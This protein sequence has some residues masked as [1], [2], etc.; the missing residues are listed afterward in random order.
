MVCLASAVSPLRSS[1]TAVCAVGCATTGQ[2]HRRLAMGH[3]PGVYRQTLLSPADPAAGGWRLGAPGQ[4]VG[5]GGGRAR[6]SQ[7]S[8]KNCL[9]GPSGPKRLTFEIQRP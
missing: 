6:R 2:H 9:L 3:T 5:T 1:S 4:A 8:L 7:C